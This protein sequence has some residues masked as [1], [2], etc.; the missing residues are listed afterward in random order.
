MKPR[1][2]SPGRRIP[3]SGFTPPPGFYIQKA[4]LSRKWRDLN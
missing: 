4:L 2:R 1:R 3:L